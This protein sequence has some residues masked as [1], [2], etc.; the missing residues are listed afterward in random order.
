MDLY[1]PKCAEPFDFHEFET[2]AERK[3]FTT[4]GCEAVEWLAPCN[5]DGKSLRA[6]TSA[7]LSDLL[8]DDMDGL[9]AMMEDFDGLMD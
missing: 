9:A 7:A 3:A 1:C 6:M 8:G 4:K 5:G 2:Q